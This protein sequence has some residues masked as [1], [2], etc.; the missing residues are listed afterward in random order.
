MMEL[1]FTP[2]LEIIKASE[3]I[4][5]EVHWLW[6]PYIPFGKVT[7][8]QGDP[9]DGKSKLMLTLA[10]LLSKGEQLPFADVEET[11]EPM[12]IIYQ[13]TEDDADDTVVPRFYSAGGDCENLVFIKEDKKSLTFSDNRIREAIEKCNAKL[14]ILDPMT[15]YI[16]DIASMNNANETRTAFNH[17]ISVAKETECAIVIIAHMNKVK[18]VSPLYRTNGSIDIAAAARSILAITKTPDNENLAERFLVQVKSNLAPLGTAIR[19]EVTDDGVDFIEEVELSA[20]DAFAAL[21]PRQGRPNEKEEAAIKFIRDI[22]SVGKQSA[23]ECKAKLEAAGFKK[24]TYKKAKKK[25]GVLSE[26]VGFIWFWYLPNDENSND[27]SNEDDI[28][29]FPF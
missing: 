4:P 13:T 9:G 15:S 24:S 27:V 20:A 16:G 22:L 17:L 29:D 12:T 28:F 11:N 7:L 26:K 23:I 1:P 10:A 25:A 14:L 3:V 5:R 6:Y 21:A 19:F 18:D 2:K 8:L